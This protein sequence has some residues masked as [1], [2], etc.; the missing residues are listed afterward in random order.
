MPSVLK[1]GRFQTA[2]E[3]KK[4]QEMYCAMGNDGGISETTNSELATL[5]IIF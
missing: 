5:P 1:E 4:C 3:R 2:N